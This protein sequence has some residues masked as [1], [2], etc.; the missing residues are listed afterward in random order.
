MKQKP[1]RL[2]GVLLILAMI[3]GILTSMPL[4]AHAEGTE[5]EDP[6]Y[7]TGTCGA[8]ASDHLEWYLFKDGSVAIFGNGNMENFSTPHGTY[9]CYAPWYKDEIVTAALYS[10]KIS[11][12][13][14]VTSIGNYAFY[15]PA[16][17]S[18]FGQTYNVD[19]P[20]TLTSIGDHA[21]ENQNK[22]T[23]IA[24]PKNVT[25][26]GTDAFKGCTAITDIDL[27]CDPRSLTWNASYFTKNVTVHILPEYEKYIEETWFNNNGK[28][29][30]EANLHSELGLQDDEDHIERN[31][32]GYF[33]TSN[34]KVFGGAVPFIVVGSF[35]GMKKSVTQGNAGFASC[36]K[37]G[38]NYY[39][40]TENQS[41][42]LYQVT[43][44]SNTGIVT[45]VSNT[46]LSDYKLFLR[47]E[48]VGTNTVKL[49]YQL[50][51]TGTGSANDVMVGGTG[52]IKIGA[53]DKARIE[54]LMDN[55][56][57]VGF[58][59]KS[60]KDFDKDG[61]QAATLGFIG[62]GVTGSNSYATFFYG[63]ADAINSS[64]STG[65]Y[66]MRLIPEL[67]FSNNNGAQ[68]TD[69]FPTNA[70]D[71]IDSGIS[72]F[73]NTETIASG[74]TKE[75]AVLFSV[76]G[77]DSNSGDGSAMIE[78]QTATFHTVTWQNPSPEYV[79]DNNTG[80]LNPTTLVQQVVKEG[81]TPVYPFDNPTLDHYNGNSF[82]FSGWSPSLTECTENVTYTATY[83]VSSHPLFIGHSVT[84]RGDIGVNFY[85]QLSCNKTQIENYHL[86]IAFDWN[87]AIKQHDEYP[88]TAEDYVSDSDVEGFYIF[89]ARC[90]VCAAEMSDIIHATAYFGDIE[91]TA[92]YDRYSVSEYAD[93]ILNPTKDAVTSLQSSQ[94]AKYNALCNLVVAMLDYGAKAQ[95]VF[96]HNKRKLANREIASNTLT[97][98]VGETVTLA[99]GTTITADTDTIETAI[100][101]A[102]D[103]S[104]IINNI[105]G[106]NTRDLTEG[107][108]DVGL[109]YNL[110][111]VVFLSKS[112]MRHYFTI[113]D[114]TAF[115]TALTARQ[116][117]KFKYSD[118]KME[119][120]NKVVYFEIEDIPAAELDKLQAFSIG[121]YTYYFSVLDFAKG[122]LDPSRPAT[123]QA[124]G[125]A[126]FWYNFYANV[127]FEKKYEEAN[128]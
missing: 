68:E 4:T 33:G 25:S 74:E 22:L 113:K 61:D 30:F 40:A 77:T 89:R 3:T 35:S 102:K 104:T 44:N 91:Y 48:Y 111:S 28:I 64:S 97:S 41:G 42:Y 95:T 2:I 16:L 71:R 79:A 20:T 103:N 8:T 85:L 66:Q 23:K 96:D 94:P 65:S 50:K 36:V 24:I 15:I 110:T 63:K 32:K 123:Q 121:S 1:R 81:E 29:T 127:F 101:T 73:W 59:M 10:S 87:G 11:I 53:D 70:E 43:T 78:E 19:L 45:G 98:V 57:Q 76:F 114:Q 38:N 107:I 72:Y 54:P 60:T 126:T 128:S 21:F 86:K 82:V 93:E 80:E 92:E 5:E 12:E 31:I 119:E 115:N 116:N 26:I 52:D 17:I 55:N 120:D 67:I 105:A 58:Y 47:R 27:Y 9:N 118:R 6:Y 69:Y 88:V 46:P 99:N 34:P 49:I 75:Y 13:D 106:T 7:A 109:E 14:G 122:L 18:F 37:I 56:T 117:D 90:N 108:N 39:I 100:T 51:Y 125:K 124:L 112:S 83:M 84:L 62:K